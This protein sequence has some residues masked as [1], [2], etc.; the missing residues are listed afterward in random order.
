MLL[1]LQQM[2]HSL[3]GDDAIRKAY[4][5]GNDTSEMIC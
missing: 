4:H 1:K 3:L 5:K 2:K